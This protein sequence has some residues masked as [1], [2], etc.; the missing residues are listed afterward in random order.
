MIH[1]SSMNREQKCT[2]MDTHARICTPFDRCVHGICTDWKDCTGRW[3]RSLRPRKALGGPKSDA[4]EICLA[5][6]QAQD[7]GRRVGCRNGETN[8]PGRRT[9]EAAARHAENRSRPCRPP[10]ERPSRSGTASK[11]CSLGLAP[12]SSRRERSKVCGDSS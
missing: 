4:R 2:E 7:A 8:R 12:P 9:L 6:L 10:R 11:F 5:D 3:E 1:F